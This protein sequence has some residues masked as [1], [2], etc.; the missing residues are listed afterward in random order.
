[1]QLRFPTIPDDTALREAVAGIPDALYFDDPNGRPD[2]RKHL[3]RA[4]AGQILT[5]LNA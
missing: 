1:V 5:E 3:T 2:H 4:F